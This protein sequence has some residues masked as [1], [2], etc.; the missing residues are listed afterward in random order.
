MKSPPLPGERPPERG[1]R[2]G[3]KWILQLASLALFALA[4]NHTLKWMATAEAV[5]AEAGALSGR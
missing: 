2:G 4:F 3:M 1:H 5:V